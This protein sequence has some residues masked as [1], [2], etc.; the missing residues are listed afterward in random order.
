MIARLKI[1]GLQ[2]QLVMQTNT[3]SLDL[4]SNMIVYVICDN[5]KAN[6]L[7]Y[8][9]GQ[10]IKVMV[11]LKKKRKMFRPMHE[12]P[13]QGVGERLRCSRWARWREP[14]TLFLASPSQVCEGPGDRRG[15]TG[16]RGPG[17]SLAARGRRPH[18]GFV[19]H[20]YRAWAAGSGADL[21]PPGAAWWAHP[22]MVT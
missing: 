8:A 17:R 9:W 4:S 14:T 5:K 3:F 7:H 19:L 15:C 13:A 12:G 10:D 2:K 6:I 11:E 22:W 20:R 21:R 1:T 18:S 16:C